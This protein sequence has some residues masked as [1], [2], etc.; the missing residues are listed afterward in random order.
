[1]RTVSSVIYVALNSALHYANSYHL[2]F[3]F[4]FFFDDIR[5]LK[6][7]FTIYT[8]GWFKKETF[9]WCLLTEWF[10]IFGFENICRYFRRQNWSDSHQINEWLVLFSLVNNFKWIDTNVLSYPINIHICRQEK[11]N[12]SSILKCDS[13]Q[14]LFHGTNAYVSVHFLEWIEFIDKV[15][16]EWQQT[17]EI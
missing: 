4:S 12:C 16:L 17:A 13:T 3:L 5:K 1:M 11:G 6:G 2:L 7:V 9:S 10:S 15:L 8:L 14:F